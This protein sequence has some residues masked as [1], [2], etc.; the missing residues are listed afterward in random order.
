LIKE[1][2]NYQVYTDQGV[3]HGAADTVQIDDETGFTKINKKNGGLIIL[4]PG[5][6]GRIELNP[7]EE[8]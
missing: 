6:Y 5:T 8:D 4:V 2:V 3:L 7:I 1:D